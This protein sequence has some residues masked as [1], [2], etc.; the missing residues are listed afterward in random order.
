KRRHL[1]RE[2]P[3]LLKLRAPA[4][5]DD[6]PTELRPFLGYVIYKYFAATW[7]TGSVITHKFVAHPGTRH[8]E[9]RIVDFGL[10]I[11]SIVDWPVRKIDCVRFANGDRPQRHKEH[12]AERGNLQEDSN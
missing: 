9:L 11:E 10:R 5:R 4:G 12:Q 1:Y 8:T 3:A 2:A 7:L 6:A